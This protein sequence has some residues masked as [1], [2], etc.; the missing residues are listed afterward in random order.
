M[1]DTGFTWTTSKQRLN[2]RTKPPPPPPPLNSTT[3]TFLTISRIAKQPPTHKHYSTNFSVRLQ[4]NEQN[5]LKRKRTENFTQQALPKAQKLLRT[6]NFIEQALPKAQKLSLTGNSIELAQQKTQ[7]QQRTGNFIE[8]ALWPP[9]PQTNP[10]YIFE[11]PPE[12]LTISANTTPT[13]RTTSGKPSILTH[14]VPKYASD[15]Y[16]LVE[17]SLINLL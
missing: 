11:V 13:A 15:N 9:Q 17:G 6:E 4:Q 2:P 7:K 16:I 12:I 14:S 3:T 5:R 10:I 8:Q 1:F